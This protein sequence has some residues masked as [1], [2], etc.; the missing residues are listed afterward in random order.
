MIFVLFSYIQLELF[1]LSGTVSLSVYSLVAAIFGMNI[2]YPWNNNHGYVFKWVCILISPLSSFI[3]LLVPCIH[4]AGSFLAGGHFWC[5]IEWINIYVNNYLF[6][7]QR[8]CRILT[9]VLS[10]CIKCLYS[11]QKWLFLSRIRSYGSVRCGM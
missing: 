7:T 5:N 8:S 9:S 10:E 1:L 6:K 2:P 11:S 3:S 4:H